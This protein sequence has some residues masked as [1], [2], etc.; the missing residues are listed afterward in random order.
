MVASLMLS[1]VQVAEMTTPST[2]QDIPST[3]TF[4]LKERHSSITPSDPSER[5]YIGLGQATQMLNV[6]TQRLMRSAILPLARRYCADKMFIRPRIRGTIYKDTMNG[7][8][9]APD[10]NKRAQIFANESFFATAYPGAQE[11]RWSS[12]ETV[13]F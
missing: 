1:H 6:T 13:Y 2:L 5:W 9:K 7:R 12:V 3:R 4:Q 10:G 8:Y 11:Q